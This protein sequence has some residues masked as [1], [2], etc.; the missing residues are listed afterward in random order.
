MRPRSS[1]LLDDNGNGS[2]AIACFN[3]ARSA[4]LSASFRS[5]VTIHKGTKGRLLCC[6]FVQGAPRSG[7]SQRPG[8]RSTPKLI[9]RPVIL[10]EHAGLESNRARHPRQEVRPDRLSQACGN[11]GERQ[12]R[13][14][15]SVKSVNE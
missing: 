15:R 2:A 8:E 11:R 7:L 4:A 12:R 3:S 9:V 13:E 14:R 10:S 5:T 6:H 1:L